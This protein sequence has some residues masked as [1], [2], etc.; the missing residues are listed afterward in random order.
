MAIISKKHKTWDVT[1][2][3][4]KSWTVERSHQFTSLL[5][6]QWNWQSSFTRINAK[7]KVVFIANV[8]SKKNCEAHL[9]LPSIR[10][11]VQDSM[12]SSYWQGQGRER[13]DWLKK[14]C[15]NKKEGI[16]FFYIYTWQCTKRFQ[17]ERGNGMFYFPISVYIHCLIITHIAFSLSR[18][19]VIHVLFVVT[20]T[21]KN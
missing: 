3:S 16:Q 7:T 20:C 12:C 19:M 18:R 8:N 13:E 21:C 15:K 6:R 17:I 1:I 2:D 14:Q 11:N 10:G 4:N 9:F 5:A